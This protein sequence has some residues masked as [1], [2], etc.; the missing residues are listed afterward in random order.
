MRLSEETLDS[1]NGGFVFLL[2]QTF[3]L[4]C[5]YLVKRPTIGLFV[6]ADCLT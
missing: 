3:F 5:S 1:L 6:V 2:L 4:T